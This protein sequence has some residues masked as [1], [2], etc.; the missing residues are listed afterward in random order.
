MNELDLD[1]TLQFDDWSILNSLQCFL[2]NDRN[3]VFAKQN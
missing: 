1:G 3:K 2:F